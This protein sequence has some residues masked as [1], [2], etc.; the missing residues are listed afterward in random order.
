MGFLSALIDRVAGVPP[1][2][3]TLVERLPDPD[4]ARG[5]F[6]KPLEPDEC[7]VEIYLESMRLEKAR[8]F[9]TTF[10]GVVY[11][12]M[13]LARLG[14]PRAEIAAV[15]KPEN[16]SA[17]NGQ[18]LQRVLTVQKRLLP[19]TPWRGNPLALE[20]GLF[21]VKTGDVLTPLI[22]FVTEISAK[23]GVSTAAMADPLMPLVSKGLDLI[24]GQTTETEIELAIDT[25]ATV[26][27]SRLMAIV[28]AP[29]GT[30]APG[31][32]SVDPSDRRLLHDGR[33][34][35]AGYCVFS[36][37]R[38]DRNPDWGAIEQLQQAYADLKG[39]IRSGREADAREALA[40]FS[41]ACIV[42]PDLIEKDGRALRDKAKA[43]VADAFEGGAQSR[44]PQPESVGRPSLLELNLYGD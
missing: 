3:W 41:R 20:L 40:A 39:A 11:A 43:M 15:S 42:S 29:R 35:N 17:L 9:A 19:A 13:G 27:E 44:G 34:V 4:P 6:G 10:D 30:Y 38:A 12:Y 32:F 31:G 28:A 2:S 1:T 5:L 36:I 8:R 22:G 26:D 18:S 25:D 24:A 23:A 33:E 37:R 14:E 7:Y 21:S 16:L